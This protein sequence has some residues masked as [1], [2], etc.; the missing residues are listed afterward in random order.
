MSQVSDELVKQAF[1]AVDNLTP[2]K[3]FGVPT[4][5][6]KIMVALEV[7]CKFFTNKDK[8][9]VYSFEHGGGWWGPNAG[10]YVNNIAEAGEFDFAEAL[11]IC[12]A[13][14]YRAGS[15]LYASGMPPEVMVPASVKTN[16]ARQWQYHLTSTQKT[17]EVTE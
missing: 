9:L 1:E 4:E 8:W 7:A 16:L 10:G 12:K 15:T 14:N 6:Q 3:C 2:E 11:R 13:A 17:E 5:A